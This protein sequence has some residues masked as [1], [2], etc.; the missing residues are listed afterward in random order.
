MLVEKAANACKIRTLNQTC[1]FLHLI[2]CQFRGIIQLLA[3]AAGTRS[4]SRRQGPDFH[5]GSACYGEYRDHFYWLSQVCSVNS[6]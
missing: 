5:E 3:D 4:G 1:V 2:L 6:F